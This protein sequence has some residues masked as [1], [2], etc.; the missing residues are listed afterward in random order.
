M[1]YYDNILKAYASTLS[2]GGSSLHNTLMTKP[3]DG[4][5]VSVQG[6]EHIIPK[7]STMGEFISAW[8]GMQKIAESI[9]LRETI[10]TYVG[11]WL[12]DGHIVFDVSYNI[13]VWAD[14]QAMGIA[15]KQKAVYDV[16][17]DK[18][19]FLSPP[20][21]DDDDDYSDIYA[22]IDRFNDERYRKLDSDLNP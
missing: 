1:N 7:E 10:P 13:P 9:Q 6:H 15:N 2:S 5:M 18:E 3:T 14:A 11:T 22:E 4:F 19:L 21:D 16:A 20:D 12:H 8:T 17:N